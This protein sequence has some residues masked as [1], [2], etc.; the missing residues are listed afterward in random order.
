MPHTLA[1]AVQV[2]VTVSNAEWVK[3]QDPKRVFSAKRDSSSQGVICYNCGKKGHYARE[4]RSP[5]RD[6]NS[7]NNRGA[8]GGL[9]RP[10]PGQNR[11]PSNSGNSGGKQIRC[12]HC[13]KLGHRRDQCPQL[14]GSNSALVSPNNHRS[15]ARFPKPTPGSQANH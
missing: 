1:E 3:A 10:A 6:G 2:A 11:N 4:C 15:A 5:R 8:A 9:G 7:G 14:M 12:F 13:K